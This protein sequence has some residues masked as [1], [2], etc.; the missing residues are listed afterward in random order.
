MRWRTAATIVLLL[1]SV[2]MAA[3]EL[4]R[5]RGGPGRNG[6]SSRPLRYATLEDFDGSFQ[7]C[8]IVFN[9]SM[10]G[11]G[12]SWNVDFPRADENLSIRLSE[13]TKAPVSMGHDDLPNHLLIN[14]R[15][16]ELFHCPFIMMTEVGRLFL[17]EEESAGLRNYLLKGG[18]LWADDFWGERAWQVFESQIRKALPAP[19][20]PIVD[21]PLTHPMFTALMKVKRIPQIPSINFWGGLGGRTS[22]QGADSATPHARAILDD[23]GRVMVF[24]THNTDFGDA[25]EREGDD[26]E[27]FLEFSVE[28]YALAV[29]VLLYAMS[30]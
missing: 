29:N 19:S 23:H 22:E 4:Q 7:F 15:Q 16:P 8:R 26:H 11:F 9:A 13:L 24:I 30:H 12:S 20:Y 2:T 1:A 27:Y 25:F 6:Y 17:D 3:A 10:N 28:G 5:G 21:L 18:F 14:L